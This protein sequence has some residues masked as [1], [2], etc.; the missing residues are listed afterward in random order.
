[1]CLSEMGLEA[2]EDDLDK[3]S[4]GRKLV[5][6]LPPAKLQ[7]FTEIFSFFDRFNHTIKKRVLIFRCNSISSPY[8]FLLRRA[9]FSLSVTRDGGGSIGT[10]ELEQVLSRHYQ[11]IMDC[12]IVYL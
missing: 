3:E 2:E 7:E 12:S 5:E 11:F 9:K 8:T 10:E 1:M 4:V 6:Q